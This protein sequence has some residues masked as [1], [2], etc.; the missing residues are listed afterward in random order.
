MEGV[1]VPHATFWRFPKRDFSIILWATAL[2]KVT[3]DR[4]N[5]SLPVFNLTNRVMKL[6]T[7]KKKTTIWIWSGARDQESINQSAH[8]V[9]WK[10]SYITN[11]LINIVW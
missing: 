8:F 10:S 6:T 9:E 3:R 1:L 2:N 5:S 4:G 7:V 11:T